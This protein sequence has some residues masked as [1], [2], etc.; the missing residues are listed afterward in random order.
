MTYLNRHR[1][2]LSILLALALV[3]SL[4]A[5]SGRDAD[6]PP[7]E[8]SSAAPPPSS[9]SPSFANPLDVPGGPEV[10]TVLM[11]EFTELLAEKHGINSDT[12]GWLYLPH[13]SI[14]DV[15]VWHDGRN[16]QYNS[17]YERRNFEKEYYFDGI[18]Y[19]DFRT[20]WGGDGKGT[21]ENLSRN[22]VIYGHSMEDIPGIRDMSL[23][24]VAKVE[25]NNARNS[26]L[27]F[28]EFKK[29][30]NED[31]ARQNPYIFFSTRDEDMAWEIFSVQFTNISIPYITPNPT[32]E[33][34]EWGPFMTR[35]NFPSEDASWEWLLRDAEARSVW[36]YD[37][38]VTTNDKI[39]TM[40]TCVYN[41]DDRTFSS[42]QNNDYRFVVM[43]RLVEKDAV[44]T[45]EAS[46]TKN[47]NPVSGLTRP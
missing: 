4:A 40:S 32:R 31:F 34:P 19:A 25:P 6:P 41:V 17:F 3:F 10:P 1:L 21:R 11:P 18:Y 37:V 23:E 5:C 29:L 30:L 46:F 15:V 38:E 16:G 13:S 27:M 24:E 28:T 33:D 14:D 8:P 42:S 44:L 20:R 43:A 47:P 39:I 45:A 35:M 36:N 2:I 9:S 26:P 12:V 7:E 22:T